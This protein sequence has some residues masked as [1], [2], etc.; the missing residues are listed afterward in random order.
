MPL[1]NPL[2]HGKDRDL[3][4]GIFD[5]QQPAVTLALRVLTDLGWWE[6]HSLG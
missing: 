6:K 1:P 4:R 2:H 5:S 3:S